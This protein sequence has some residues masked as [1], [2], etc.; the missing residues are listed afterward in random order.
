MFAKRYAWAMKLLLKYFIAVFLVF[1]TFTKIFCYSHLAI[2]FSCRL[3]TSSRLNSGR[4][5]GMMF[6]HSALPSGLW[7]HN[8]PSRG[9]WICFHSSC[10]FICPFVS[11]I[12][13]ASLNCLSRA[14]PPNSPVTSNLNIGGS[15]SPPWLTL[16]WCASVG[17]G[18]R[19][20]SAWDGAWSP[21]TVDICSFP[22]V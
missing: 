18:F 12:C 2:S 15:R 5:R 9:S 4:W 21:A 8:R 3:N 20:P 14:S 1:L 7:R 19:L 10:L 13:I 17:L 22:L 11:L 6:V 16:T